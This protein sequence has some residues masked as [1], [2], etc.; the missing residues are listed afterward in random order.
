MQFTSP[1]LRGTL[2]RR[3]KRFFADILL[4]SGEHITAHCP[5]TG[6]M[7]GCAEPGFITYVSPANN[8]KRKLKFTWELVFTPQQH[9][10]GINTQH[11]NTLASEAIKQGIHPL[12]E[13]LQA[14]R[15]EVKA[16][17]GQS[18]FDFCL[19]QQDNSLCYLEVK[20]VTLA[21]GKQ[22]Y[23]PDAVT[24][25]GTKHV[26]GLA[27]LAR[28]GVDTCL[29]FCVQHSAIEQVSVAHHI[30]P[31]YALAVEDAVAAG[32]KVLAVSCK[33]SEEKITINQLL[34]VIL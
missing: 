6:A 30:D 19:T 29:F 27:E 12:F 4:D 34:P 26:Q 7:T 13:H 15:R 23:F 3:Y 21:D 18:R 32:V 5:N 11:A 17:D 25:R 2:I 9:W 1:L 22:G 14:V 28:T 16:P 33:M 20:S 8:P 24:T 31:A 10:I